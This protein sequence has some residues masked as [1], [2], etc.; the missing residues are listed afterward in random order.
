MKKLK[1]Q[2]AGSTPGTAWQAQKNVFTAGGCNQRAKEA[3]EAK[4]GGVSPPRLLHSGPG[5]QI[6]LLFN[7]NGATA[8]YDFYREIKSPSVKN[9]QEKD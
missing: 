3:S 2:V 5:V 6:R 1:P 9:L 4:A 7:V 8:R